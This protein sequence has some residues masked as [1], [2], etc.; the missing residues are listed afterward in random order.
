[1]TQRSSF[2]L[3]CCC[4]VS[5]AW[6]APTAHAYLSHQTALV[7]EWLAADWQPATTTISLNQQQILESV[8][9]GGNWL[10]CSSGQAVLPSG[11]SEAT[12]LTADQPCVQVPINW[13]PN[14]LHQIMLQYQL[15]VDR[16]LEQTET[17]VIHIYWND[18]LVGWLYQQTTS[19]RWLAIKIPEST[20]Q[21]GDLTVEINVGIPRISS[22]E[23]QLLHVTTNQVVLSDHSQLT[24]SSTEVGAKIFVKDPQS[25]TIE[26]HLSGDIVS[27]DLL[28]SSDVLKVWSIDKAG[29]LEPKR[30]I[31]ILHAASSFPA[32]TI[33]WSHLHEGQLSVALRTASNAIHTLATFEI[34]TG[35]SQLLMTSSHPFTSVIA[36]PG[37][38]G[39]ITT[40]ATEVPPDLHAGRI[41]ALDQ[42][43]RISEA[44]EPIFW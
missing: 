2:F 32:P 41:R 7:G 31:S 3:A 11:S 15:M 36:S 34:E 44:S 14:Q 4:L 22:V 37:Y 40:V 1:M 26:Q 29:N 42:F 25:G 24:V 19:P 10:D 38:L 35:D 33:L 9:D 30:S 39:A 20:D 21:S 43:G 13:S 27:N 17:P 23:F 12:V 18:Q 28:K 16:D 5:L 8:T 6:A